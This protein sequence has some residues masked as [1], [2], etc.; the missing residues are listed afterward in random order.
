[1]ADAGRDASADPPVAR[2]PNP[3]ALWA[4]LLAGGA[5]AAVVVL[6]ALADPDLDR[7]ALR[8]AVGTWAFLTY[9]VAGTVAWW[10]RPANAFGPLM[11]A[12]GFALAAPSLQWSTVPALYT[13]GA[14]F[15][16]APAALF[17]HVFLA[18]PSGRLARFP[19][20]VLVV[21]AYVAA[22]GLQAGVLVFGALD[23]RNLLAV[24]DE[25]EIADTVQDLQLLTLALAALGGVVVFVARRREGPP[26]RRVASALLVDSSALGLV[27]LA[28][29][30]L[31]GALQLPGFE[32]VRLITFVVI[33]LG[34]IAFLAGLLDGPRA[35]APG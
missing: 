5:V 13:A 7:P 24:S 9:V 19:E 27:L 17:L 35:A 25:P 10:R 29:L 3:F 1:M 20:R 2:P 22:L 15:A 28:V 26:T 23:P 12:A 4:I 21:V 14:L 16:L 30:L 31:A 6:L 32:I 33:G 34:P 11:I 8:A 18:F